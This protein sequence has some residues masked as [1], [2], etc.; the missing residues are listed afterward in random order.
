MFP[1][2]IPSPCAYGCGGSFEKEN[3][4]SDTNIN[5]TGSVLI[6][7]LALYFVF[8]INLGAPIASGQPFF[9]VSCDDGA[10]SPCCA[11]RP[12]RTGPLEDEGSPV[13]SSH[14]FIFEFEPCSLFVS[15]HIAL[16]AGDGNRPLSSSGRPPS[17]MAL[18]S[19][20]SQSS[21]E[22]PRLYSLRPCNEYIPPWQIFIALGA[23]ILAGCLLRSCGSSAVTPYAAVML[24]ICG[25]ILLFSR[26]HHYA[27][28]GSHHPGPCPYGRSGALM[29]R[30]ASRFPVS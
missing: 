28:D 1:M 24:V 23:F 22:R 7:M 25:G 27:D 17:L 19:Y 3:S 12:P 20:S 10:E 16:P 15:H 9:V 11:I 6:W 21:Q 8:F 13:G 4:M 29:T 26:N 2:M 30:V 5:S 14:R 18:P